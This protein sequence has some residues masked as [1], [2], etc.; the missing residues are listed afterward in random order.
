MWRQKG[1][2]CLPRL[3][4]PTGERFFFA[5]LYQIKNATKRQFYDEQNADSGAERLV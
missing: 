1:N 4:A 5:P 3:V 2:W